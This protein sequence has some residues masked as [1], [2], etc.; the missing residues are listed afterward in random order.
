MPDSTSPA[1]EMRQGVRNFKRALTFY[2]ATVFPA[3]EQCSVVCTEC[4]ACHRQSMA[5]KC[6]NVTRRNTFSLQLTEGIVSNGSLFR[7][8]TLSATFLCCLPRASTLETISTS[9]RQVW[10]D[11][12]AYRILTQSRGDDV[13]FCFLGKNVVFANVILQLAQVLLRQPQPLLIRSFLLKEGLV[14]A[15]WVIHLRCVAMLRESDS[16]TSAFFFFCPCGR[17]SKS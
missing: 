14:V 13:A 11:K 16:L 2:D 9:N 10:A 1:T 8:T 4:Q 17:T 6:P 3:C 7:F 15:S 5:A 12:A